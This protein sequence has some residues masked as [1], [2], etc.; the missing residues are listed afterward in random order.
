MMRRLAN[1]LGVVVWMLIAA[2]PALAQGLPLKDGNS[3]ALA[4]VQ[5]CGAENCLRAT[6]PTTASGVGYEG[7]VGVSGDSPVTSSGKRFNPIHGTEGGGLRMGV[8]NILW[9]DTFNATAQNTGKYKWFSA[10]LTGAQAAGYVLLNNSSLTTA[11]GNAALQTTKVFPL[12]AKQELRASI[13]AMH[14]TAPQAN[15]VTEWGLF[16][17][18]LPGTAAPADGCFFRFN[19]SAEFRGVCSFNGTEVQTGAITAT[20]ANV[21]HDYLIVVQ[22]NTAVFYVDNAVVGTLTL[23]TD[24]PS[25]GQPLMQATVPLTL[26]HYNTATP[27]SLAMQFKV[28]DVFVIAIGPDMGRSWGT[29]KAGFGHMAYQ[30]QNGGTMGSTANYANSANPTAAVPTNTTAALGTGLGGQFWE[31]HSLALGTDGIVSSFQNPAGGVNQS[32]R[33]LI[34]H[35]VCIDSTI[36]TVLA[37]GPYVIAWSLAFGHTAVSLATAESTS[38]VT[39]STTTKAPRRIALGKMAVTAAQAVA[40]R[41]AGAPVCARFDSGPLV[42]APGEF[43]A[44]VTK[45][46]TGGTVGTTGVIAHHIWFDGYFE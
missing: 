21:N 10:T 1:W 27:P 43:I 26:R 39:P 15:A 11:S 17:A 28:S 2:G 5:A 38:F 34:I 20:S 42:I 18:T 41:V 7:L 37:G 24:A 8:P 9:D 31:T 33:N 46:E 13:S 12:F 32:G 44:T 3:S 4:D 23:S 6:G 14:T 25:Q 45:H 16:T 35:G 36:Q 22:T 29:Q 19:A 30:G 40:T